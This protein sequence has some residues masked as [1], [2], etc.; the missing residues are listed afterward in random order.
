MEDTDFYSKL[1]M[2]NDAQIILKDLWQVCI[3]IL[4]LR[5]S[6]LFL[7]FSQQIMRPFACFFICYLFS[8]HDTSILYASTIALGSRRGVAR[9]SK[10]QQ[11]HHPRSHASSCS[12]STTPPSY[13]TKV[14][15]LVC[16]LRWKVT[17]EIVNVHYRRVA[18]H[19]LG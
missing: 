16:C 15:S 2:R 1:R 17:G 4:T 10:I 11:T 19:A 12:S 13:W 6:L 8:A 14:G 18:C 3:H 5:T 9:G 7:R